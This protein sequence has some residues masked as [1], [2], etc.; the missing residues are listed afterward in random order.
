M[1]SS[2]NLN[3]FASGLLYNGDILAKTELARSNAFFADSAAITSSG[4]KP[5]RQAAKLFK[6]VVKAFLASD[7]TSEPAKLFIPVVAFISPYKLFN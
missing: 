5:C 1:F 2:I 3:F 7:N 6:S 4:D